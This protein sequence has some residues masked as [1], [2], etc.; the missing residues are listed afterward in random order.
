[1]QLISKHRPFPSHDYFA[2][3][4][5]LWNM[6]DVVV[7]VVVDSFVVIAVVDDDVHVV[8]VDLASNCH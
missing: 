8:V 5:Y 7:V 1:M 4:D 2:F 3:K 6:F